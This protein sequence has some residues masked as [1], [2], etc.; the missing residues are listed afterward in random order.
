MKTRLAQVMVSC[1]MLSGLQSCRYMPIF[2]DAIGKPTPE[3]LAALPDNVERYPSGDGPALQARFIGPY[4]LAA[5]SK[6]NVY[7]AERAQNRIRKIS[8]DGMVTTIAL[9]SQGELP[10]QYESDDW[11]GPLA[12][13]HKDNV[14]VANQNQIYR[15]TSDEKV[16]F[17]AGQLA[18][19]ETD[20]VGNAASFQNLTSMACDPQGN[21]FLMDVGNA[22]PYDVQV[23]KVTPDGKVTTHLDKS[24]SKLLT[25]EALPGR[26]P[27]I[28]FD[29]Q[30]SLYIAET[31][32]SSASA[33]E[34]QFRVAKLV[35]KGG[36]WFLATGP[37]VGNPSG[38]LSN[39]SDGLAADAEGNLYVAVNDRNIIRKVSPSGD[40]SIAVGSG[41]SGSTDGFALRSELRHPQGLAIDPNGNLFI[42]DTGNHKVRVLKKDGKVT[43]LAGSGQA[44]HNQAVDSFPKPDPYLVA[45][46][47]GQIAFQDKRFDEAIGFSRQALAL[48]P[49]AVSARFQLGSALGQLKQIDEGLELLLEV[50][51]KGVLFPELSQKMSLYYAFK[52]NC[53]KAA[54]FYFNIKMPPLQCPLSFEAYQELVLGKSNGQSLHFKEATQH[55][56]KALAI[57]PDLIEAKF[58]LAITLAK[59]QVS[60]VAIKRF[61]EVEAVRPDY[62]DLYQQLSLALSFEGE[63][64]IK[65]KSYA[66]KG[67]VTDFKCP[68]S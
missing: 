32:L 34:S 27:I 26:K 22:F 17:I 58:Q 36:F 6:G 24:V 63:D 50:Y 54:K 4:A 56:E 65:A 19:G 33:T 46:F 45:I 37:S 55:F 2:T 3:G 8:S 7:V 38:Y 41:F 51:N 28:T 23:R 20:G 10:F 61:M 21:L 44:L 30:G 35:G 11:T 68:R 64:C 66:D 31:Y 14:Y 18:P 39:S 47:Q 49:D 67:G 25:K 53:E 29:A 9:N 5:D 57:Q 40:V 52:G 16:S 15:I 1:F 48:R 12:V 62:P 13:D 43:T 60:G 42:A 59:M